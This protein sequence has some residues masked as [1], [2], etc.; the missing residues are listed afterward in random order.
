MAHG[1]HG[2]MAMLQ[3]CAAERAQS[4]AGAPAWSLI[5]KP[6]GHRQHWVHAT[7]ACMYVKAM[8]AWWPMDLSMLAS[9]TYAV[10]FM[11]ANAMPL[12]KPRVV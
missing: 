4:T 10:P 7:P 8:L 12:F 2:A 9:T 1:L 6:E 3:P 11:K 5:A